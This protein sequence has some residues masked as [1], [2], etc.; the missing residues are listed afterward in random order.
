MGKNVE[1]REMKFKLRDYQQDAVDGFFEQ[2][3]SKPNDDQLIIAP[4]GAGKTAI[5]AA[6]LRKSL[7]YGIRS[8]VMARRSELLDQGHSRWCEWFPDV[9]DRAGVYSAKLGLREF[10]QDIIFASAQS[11]CGKED[12][13]GKRKLLLI[14]EAHEI[15]PSSKE[16]TQY[17]KILKAFRA[18][19]DERV[20]LL[21][22]T[23]SPYRLDGGLIFGPRQQFQSVAHSIPL[24]DLMGQGYLTEPE[25]LDVSTVDLSGVRKTAGDFNRAEVETRFLGNSITNE[26]VEA[27]NQKGCKHIIV[28]SSG[29]AHANLLKHELQAMGED[30]CVIDG[31]TLPLIR[32]SIIEKFKNGNLKWL[33]NCDILTTGFDAT[34]IDGV[35][36]ARATESPGLFY[37]M[38][39]RGFRLHEGKEK[40]YVLDYGGNTERHGAINSD[41]FGIDTIKVSTGEGEAPK[42]CCPK[43]FSVGP[44]GARSCEVCGLE[45]PRKPKEFVATKAKI[46]EKPVRY[47]VIDTQFNV[48]K[49]RDGKK[50]TLRVTHKVVD[51]GA[52]MGITYIME[53]ICIEHDDGSYPRKMARKWWAQ[54]SRTDCPETLAEAMEV[55]NVIG[56]AEFRHVTAKREGKYWRI[57]SH[58]VGLA[59]EPAWL[60]LGSDDDCPF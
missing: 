57:V 13:F 6:V 4:T 32:Q 23:A 46:I 38:V 58:D 33:V 39:G 20:K 56:L 40:C 27:C 19:S 54:V 10:R 5:I 50:D 14:D 45:F 49:G 43:C 28:F 36:I 11:I 12:L 30:A 60:E 44:A 31:E 51:E 48:N 55:I 59:P 9:A 7:E 2:A 41:S 29:V 15:P 24:T 35:V 37:Q 8:V 25:T 16:D 3:R 34:C 26:M 1:V 22:L 47:K 52:P 17:Q 53:Y 42:R 21:G 18:Q